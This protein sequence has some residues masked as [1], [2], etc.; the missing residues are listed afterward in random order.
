[1][2][3]AKQPPQDVNGRLRLPDIPERNPEEVTSYDSLHHE[4][5][6]LNLRHHLIAE[7]TD[8]ERLLFIADHWIVQDARISCAAGATPT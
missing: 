3:T 6:A 1:M 7:G 5:S 8:P 2:V 4:G